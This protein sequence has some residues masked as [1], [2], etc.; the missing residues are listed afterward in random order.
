MTT[1]TRTVAILSA[2]AV[3]PLIACA[4]MAPFRDSVANTNVALALVLIVVAAAASGLRTAGLVAAFSAG[5]WFDFFL[6]QPYHQFSITDRADQETMVLLVLVGAAVTEI[7]LWGRRQQARSS[8]EKGYLSGVV[9]AAGAAAAGTIST[10][11]LIEYVEDRLVD[12]LSLDGCRFVHGAQRSS[13]PRLNPDGSV[14]I[15]TRAVDVDRLG[16]PTDDETELLAE[17]GGAI[18]GR[19]LLTA[20]THVSRPSLE[21]RLVAVALAGQ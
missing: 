19:F 11:A 1:S 3:L 12:V 15:G 18:R 8:R 13:H 4:V 20:S 2:A 7:A 10:S 16:L 17:S 6:T 21:Q 5:A 9:T 14:T